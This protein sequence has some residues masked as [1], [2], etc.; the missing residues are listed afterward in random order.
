MCP[1]EKNSIN[2]WNIPHQLVPRFPPNSL[3]LAVWT[4]DSLV[5]RLSWNANIYRGE[6]LVSLLRKHNVIKIGPEQKGNILLSTS[7]LPLAFLTWE[8]IPGS[9]H[10]H[11]F[12]VRVP[13]RWSLGT[14]LNKRQKTAEGPWTQ[15]LSSHPAN[16]LLL[17]TASG[18]KERQRIVLYWNEVW[19]WDKVTV[20]SL[21]SSP[22]LIWNVCHFDSESDL[23]WG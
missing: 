9:P 10:L 22:N 15:S 14:R 16:N 20:S 6:S 11:N 13:E 19:K 1:R 5:P 8:K 12:N 3:L 21:V 7:S 17:E 2:K 23:C 18:M 4:R